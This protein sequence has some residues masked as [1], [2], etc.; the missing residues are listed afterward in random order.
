M[1]SSLVLAIG[2]NPLAGEDPTATR[3][4]V[5]TRAVVVATFTPTAV[6][7]PAEQTATAAAEAT[8]A[9]LTAT[10]FA[11]NPPPTP[12]LANATVPPEDLLMPPAATLT[13]PAGAI[14]ATTGSFGWVFS[15]E[16]GT[17]AAVEVPLVQ[18]EHEP[19]TVAGGQVFRL[20][21]SGR[22]FRSLP[23]SIEGGVYNFEEN[24]GIPLNPQGGTSDEPAFALKTDP[25]QS[26]AL[27]PGDAHFTLDVPPG[28]YA[29]RLQGRWP[30][31][32][33]VTS[34]PIFVTW[35]FNVIVA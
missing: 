22:E 14:P 15:D 19:A 18:F 17:V 7:P 34:T 9:A 33:G 2:C 27:N 23:L 12:T 21:L 32:P 30:P 35:V 26:L 31:F 24:S 6:V 11:L 1:V 3:P 16:L 20:A 29:I 13:G 10:E 25:D 5:P 4:P 28:H 8:D